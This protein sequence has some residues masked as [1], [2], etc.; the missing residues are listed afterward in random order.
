M[1][2]LSPEEL[3]LI[4]SMHL[5]RDLD[6]AEWARVQRDFTVLPA[7]EGQTI[8]HQGDYADAFYILLSG[9]VRLVRSESGEDAD[10]VILDAGMTFG[11]EALNRRQARR[12]RAEAVA[13]SRILCW[14]DEDLLLA[15]RNMPAL[16]PYLDTMRETYDLLVSLPMPW[17]GPRE[18]VYLIA[19]RHPV[20]LWLKLIPPLLIGAVSSVPLLALYFGQA[21][22]PIFL[23]LALVFLLAIAIWVGLVWLDWSNDFS[24]ITNRRVLFHERVILLYDSRREVPLEAVLSD[25]VTTTF[26]GRIFGFGTVVI[27]T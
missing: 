5:F 22:N 18:V 21:Q 9:R 7:V 13:P 24:I 14:Q 20:F 19:R 10:L 2:D 12:V 15:E 6:E 27:K 1:S 26:L 23:I 16:G 11:E 8:F 17:R 3:N 25:D 4:R